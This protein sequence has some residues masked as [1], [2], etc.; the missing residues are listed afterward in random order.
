MG[1]CGLARIGFWDPWSLSGNSLVTH[2]LLHGRVIATFAPPE[3]YETTVR[4][5]WSPAGQDG[6][7]LEIEVRTRSVGKLRDL[8]VQILNSFAVGD[9]GLASSRLRT[10]VTPERTGRLGN[11]GREH[12]PTSDP[13]SPGSNVV[14]SPSVME[15]PQVP[16]RDGGLQF[17]S[18]VHPEDVSRV[19]DLPGSPVERI[20]LFG[21]DLERGVVLR[22]RVR[23]WW[24]PEGTTQARWAQCA[25]EFLDEPPP[26]RT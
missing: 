1:L 8:E 21:H 2:E 14:S 11:D 19:L 9:P 7:S 20:A 10:I 25:A 18:L 4:A 5:A 13:D 23:A 3:W 15:R 12:G 16:I 24:L 6:M 22:G 26:L 17:R